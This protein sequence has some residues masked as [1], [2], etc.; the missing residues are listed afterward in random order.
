MNH[1]L[2]YHLEKQTALREALCTDKAEFDLNPSELTEPLNLY[3]QGDW[4]VFV[5]ANKIMVPAIYEICGEQV[6]CSSL[7][8]VEF[9]A[10]ES[11]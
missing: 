4:L 1:C 2:A 5:D 9:T 11:L 6:L 8:S 7:T 3:L 10:D